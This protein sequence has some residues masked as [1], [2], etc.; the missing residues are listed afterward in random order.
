M[1][2]R[3]HVAGWVLYLACLATALCLTPT[4]RPIVERALAQAEI[5]KGANTAL[6]D[7]NEK[8]AQE[9]EGAHIEAGNANSVAM[10][11]TSSAISTGLKARAAEKEAIECQ[12]ENERMRPIVAAVSG[13]WWFPGGNAAIYAFKKCSLS[14]LVIIAGLVVILVVIKVTTGLSLGAMFNPIIGFFSKIPGWI[15]RAGK[16]VKDGLSRLKPKPKPKE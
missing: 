13:P 14:L 16:T 15:S 8:L 4:E 3:L 2:P 7:A 5:A 10:K 12:K 1:R 9:A 11:A 6:K